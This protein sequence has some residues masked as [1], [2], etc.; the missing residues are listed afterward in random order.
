VRQRES[1]VTLG[2]L[3]AGLAHE[4]NNPAAA[5]IRAVDSLD[6]ACATMMTSLTRLA[7]AQITA[8]QF[9]ALDVLRQGVAGA[10]PGLD[11]LARADR[12]EALTDWLTD[13]GILRAWSMAPA[14]ADAGI[15]LAWC[16]RVADVLPGEALRPAMEWVAST[17][18]VS[19][20][21]TDV[22]ESTG[23]ISALV[24]SVRSYTQMDRASWQDIDLT[25]GLDSTLVMLGHQLKRGVTVI[26][27][28]DPAVPHIQAYAGELNQVWT[29]LISNAIDAMDGSGVLHIGVHLDGED[30]VVEIG[31]TGS[32]MPPE[33]AERAFEA[34][35]TT[36]DVGQGTGLGLDIARRIV[37]ERH[38]GDITITSEPGKTVL[39][40]RLPI[41]AKRV[42]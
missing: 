23:R 2:T 27:D 14:L 35:Y 5:A 20:L 1:L 15:D 16:D 13:H 31:D 30:V 34:F 26:K 4:L 7:Q 40:V 21:M 19:M 36:K 32:G 6:E 8:D 39:A 12:E 29:N 9:S 42:T 37:V 24:S 33:V 38:G 17:W 18:S 25:D 28:Y 22:K 11:A 10:D 41:A 3:A